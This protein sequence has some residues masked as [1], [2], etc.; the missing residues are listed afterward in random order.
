[1]SNLMSKIKEILMSKFGI[2]VAINIIDILCRHIR[3]KSRVNSVCHSTSRRVSH[4][5]LPIF[6]R[7]SKDVHV[8]GERMTQRVCVYVISYPGF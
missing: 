1:M 3:R 2:P 4:V 8:G 5:C 6:S 7:H